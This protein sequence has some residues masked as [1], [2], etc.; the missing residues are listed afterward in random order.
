MESKNKKDTHVP[1]THV[2]HF[3]IF[4]SHCLFLKKALM[5]E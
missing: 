1:T 2:W 3:A 5:L 4:A